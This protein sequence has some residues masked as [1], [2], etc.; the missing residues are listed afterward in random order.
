MG[1]IRTRYIVRGVVQGVGFRPHV[2]NVAAA[3]AITGFCGNDD[4]SVFL[5]AQ[6]EA[7]TVAEFFSQ[8]ISTLPPLAHVVSVA[9]SSMPVIAETGFRIV[10]SKHSAGARTLLPPDVA[11]C[12][13]CRAEMRDPTNRR[14]RYPFITCTNCGPRLSIITDLPYDRPN[15]TMRKFPMCAACEAEYTDPTDRRFHAQPIS[16]WDCGPTLWLEQDGELVRDEPIAAAQALLAQGK[17]LAVKGLGGFHLMCD[18][19]NANAVATLRAR[20]QRPA[21]PFALMIPYSE[22]STEMAADLVRPIRITPGEPGEGIAPGL[23]ELGIMAPYTP[24]HELLVTTTL[25]ATSG[26]ASGEPLCYTNEDARAKL[27]HMADAFLMHDR[28]IY[29]PVEDSVVRDNTPVRRSRGLAPLPVPIPE[30]PNVLAVGGELKNT[31]AFAVDGFAHISA[32][33]GDMHSLATQEAFDRAVAQMLGTHRNAPEL[34]VCDLHPNY[35]T[36][37]W[38]ER[39]CDKHDIPLLQ[40]QHHAAHAYA[41]LA[42]HDRHTGVVAT[43]DGTGYGTDRTIWGGEILRITG[44]TWERLWHIPSFPLVGGDLAVKQPWRILQGIAHAWQLDLPSPNPLVAS[45]LRSGVG[46]VQTT[47]LGRIFDAAAALLD[48][49]LEV[50]YEAQAAMWFEQLA[51]SG[52]PSNAT[53]IADALLELQQTRDAFRFHHAIARIVASALR[54]TG[55]DIVGISGGCALNRV[56]VELLREELGG[57]ELLTHR[58]VPPNDGGLCLGQAVAG[59]LALAST[60]PAGVVP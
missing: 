58:V 30:G 54:S 16:C 18:A 10:E 40:V 8:V 19:A 9:E 17:I 5:E 41:L 12:A 23:R 50:T 60:T 33:I 38:A 44:A 37:A 1:V 20:K 13:D 11:M 32:H 7:S 57:V 34:V 3:F 42:E 2:A 45:Q 15:T 36:T 48:P 27:G 24:L 28:D 6:G 35:A 47:S 31:F 21:K 53:T 22:T 43:L 56:L 55:E 14:Y 46:V 29:V 49:E 52:H 39:Y 4:S 51:T 25:V 26:N 59:R